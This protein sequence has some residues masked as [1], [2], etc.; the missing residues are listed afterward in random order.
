MKILVI[1][2]RYQSNNIGGEDIVYQNELK[3][4][5]D[6]LGIKNVFSYARIGSGIH[7]YGRRSR[8]RRVNIFVEFVTKL[9]YHI[10]HE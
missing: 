1:H 3:S 5:Q 2:N 7:Y 4:L 6:G 9:W 10:I 8:T